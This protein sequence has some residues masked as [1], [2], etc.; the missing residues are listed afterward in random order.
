MLNHVQLKNVSLDP[1]RFK[2]ICTPNEHDTQ[3]RNADCYIEYTG[4][5]IVEVV[6]LF[7]QRAEPT[8]ARRFHLGMS[9]D[10]YWKKQQQ[11]IGS[12]VATNFLVIL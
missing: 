1:V 5:H 11:K 2:T 8:P 6:P 7:R 10:E 3:V 4:V 12:F 9:I